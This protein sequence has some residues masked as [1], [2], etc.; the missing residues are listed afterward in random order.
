[1]LYSIMK[2]ILWPINKVLFRFEAVNR[3]DLDKDKRLILCSNHISAMDP[4]LIAMTF[5]RKISFMAKIEL[6][7]NKLVGSFLRGLGAIPVDREKSDLKAI[8]SSLGV[9][10]EEKVLGIFP[11]GTRV[12]SIAEENMKT[13]IGYLAYRGQADILPVEIV[14]SYK[15]FRK[16]KVVYKEP[17]AIED[18]KDVDKKEVYD[19]ITK[20]IY[21]AIYNKE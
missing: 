9:L 13:G 15:P 7:K 4:I 1:M 8:K 18:Y 2:V 11:E 10:K 16:M 19:L 6:F 5:N 14:G 17:I 20:D 3:P 12:K 21:R